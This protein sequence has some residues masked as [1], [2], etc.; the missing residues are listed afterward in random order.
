MYQK[1]TLQRFGTLR[2]L[3]LI[4]I[5]EDG[6]GGIWGSGRLDGDWYYPDRS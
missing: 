1:P 4:G 5:G 6:D 2:D 3:T